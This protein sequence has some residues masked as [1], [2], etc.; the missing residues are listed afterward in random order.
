MGLEKCHAKALN[1]V[2]V[3]GFYDILEQVVQE[4]SIKKENTWNMDKQ[5]VQLGIGAKVA[6]IV[7]CDQAAVYSV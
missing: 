4:F 6:A 5:G 7:N 2:A 3:E 1:S